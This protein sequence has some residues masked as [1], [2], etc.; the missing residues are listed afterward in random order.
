MSKNGFLISLYNQLREMQSEEIKET[1]MCKEISES[2]ISESPQ[3]IWALLQSIF[4][5]TAQVINPSL[6]SFRDATPDEVWRNCIN[7]IKE[8]LHSDPSNLIIPIAAIWKKE[9]I[10]EVPE[11]SKSVQDAL[12]NIII[13]FP[14]NYIT[15]IDRTL[16]NQSEK[17]FLKYSNIDASLRKEIKLMLS[18]EYIDYSL[19]CEESSSMGFFNTPE[20]IESIQPQNTSHFEWLNLFSISM[21]IMEGSF[22]LLNK[23]RKCMPALE[24][25]AKVIFQSLGFNR[26]KECQ[27]MSLDSINKPYENSLTSSKTLFKAK[28]NVKFVCGDDNF[29]QFIKKNPMFVDKSLFIKQVLD[30]KT[31]PRLLIIRPRRWGKSLNLS[32]LNSFLCADVNSE[33][34]ILKHNSNYKIFS[35]GKIKDSQGNIIFIKPLFI[36]TADGG[37]YLAAAGQSPVVFITFTSASTKD[38][39]GADPS[40]K[41]MRVAIS[42]AY[43]KHKY[44]IT[45]LRSKLSNESSPDTLNDINIQL[46]KFNGYLNKDQTLDIED[47]IHFLI[48]LIFENLHR[49]AYVMIDEFDLPLNSLTD[50]AYAYQ[51]AKSIISDMLTNACNSSDEDFYLERIILAGVFQYQLAGLNNFTTCSVLSPI[52]PTAFGFT[53]QEVNDF[54]DTGFAQSPCLEKQ[55]KEMKKWYKGYLIGGFTIYSPWSIMNCLQR[56]QLKQENSIASYWTAPESLDLIKS[57]IKGHVVTG[58][59]KQLFTEE[60]IGVE[61]QEAT[62]IEDDRNVI[63]L[64]KILLF[65]GYLTST[66]LRNTYVLP[67]FEVKLY[68]YEQFFP[69]WIKADFQL[70]NECELKNILQGLADNVENLK[71][72]IKILDDKS[73]SK[74]TQHGLTESSFQSLLGGAVLSVSPVRSIPKHILYSEIVNVYGKRSYSIFKPVPGRSNIYIIQEYKK[75]ESE[76]AVKETLVNAFWQIYSQRYLSPVIRDIAPGSAIFIVARAIIFYRSKLDKWHICAKGFK[77]TLDQAVKL[78]EI[79]SDGEHGVLGKTNVLSGVEKI[80][81]KECERA[82]F[83]RPHD[84]TNIYKLLRKYS[85]EED[86]NTEMDENMAVKKY[87]K[88]NSGKRLT[89][90]T[91]K[92][93]RLNEKNSNKITLKYC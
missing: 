4:S 1:E 71:E 90:N 18:K 69:A 55:K 47:S 24:Q 46:E 34:N 31:N 73:I 58:A 76:A 30:N 7:H 81:E 10:I 22:P 79:F 77:H 33:G 49:K 35:K 92:A 88:S 64:L 78:D 66:K 68:F 21:C 65:S 62:Q 85:E 74:L 89:A 75:I 82:A 9:G 67:N 17:I 23:S 27:I 11:E 91:N 5:D 25:R 8:V 87:K 72:Y 19:E 14:K 60:K 52:F 2:I 93:K 83:L 32:M 53:E 28:E 20:I 57:K 80:S 36:A 41:S 56:M 16:H 39:G 12:W 6:A 59:L 43:S 84:V 61:F 44:L 3:Y 63:K 13:I 54:I 40:Y 70:S 29:I 42:K 15:C 45:I 38:F 86:N 48:Q 50:D 37:K 51:N 26:E